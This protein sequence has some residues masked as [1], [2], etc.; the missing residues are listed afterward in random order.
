MLIEPADSC[1]QVLNFNADVFGLK[2]S[3]EQPAGL[4][5]SVTC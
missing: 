4:A 5:V 2:A 1:L 3:E